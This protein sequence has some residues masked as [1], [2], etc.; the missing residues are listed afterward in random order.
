[1]MNGAKKLVAAGAMLAMIC[2]AHAG[3][4]LNASRVGAVDVAAAAK[5]YEAAFG[6]KEVMHFDLPGGGLEVLMNF[7][8]TVDA[9]KANTGAQIV[10]MHR[11]SDAV[12]DAIPHIILN[13]TSMTETVKAVTAAGGKMQGEPREFGKTGIM[14]GMAIDPAGNIIEL[15]QQPKH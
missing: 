3:A 4:S 6:L 5:F 7:G 15:I 14:I 11:D 8:D 9:A 10:V 1:M 2:G 13:V 12:K